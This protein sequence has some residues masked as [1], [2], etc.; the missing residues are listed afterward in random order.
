MST[1]ETTIENVEDELEIEVDFDFEPAEKMTY[2]TPACDA[3]ITINEVTVA[4]KE[5]CLTKD[6]EE[7]M[8]KEIMDYIKFANEENDNHRR[9]YRRW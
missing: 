3:Q 2:Y 9:N 6:E 4:G 5:I 8:V 7:R 1:Y